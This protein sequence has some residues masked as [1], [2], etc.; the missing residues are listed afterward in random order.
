MARMHLAALALFAATG[1]A[2][3]QSVQP[4]A[5]TAPPLILRLEGVIQNNKGAA[6]G[7]GF[8]AVSLG[9][10]GGS[11]DV[12]RWLGVTKARTLGGDQTLSGRDVLDLVA[13][14][15][16]NFLVAGPEKVVAQ[17]RDAP[18]GTPIRVEGLVHRGSRTFYL[19]YVEA[20]AGAPR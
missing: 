11:S 8:A 6:T 7:S 9:F 1:L 3:A 15:T 13:S 4:P 10:F 12:Q 20:Q 19:R 17:L 5:A 16:P 2:V 14:F 18:P